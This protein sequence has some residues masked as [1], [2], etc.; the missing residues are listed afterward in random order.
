MYGI[1]SIMGNSNF[2][3][4]TGELMEFHAQQPK[5]PMSGTSLLDIPSSVKYNHFHVKPNNSPT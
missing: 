1:G 5:V 3:T 4:F 2:P